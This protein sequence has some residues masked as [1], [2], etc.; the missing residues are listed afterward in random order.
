MK[1]LVLF[2]AAIALTIISFA[3][4]QSAEMDMIR[5]MF[6]KEWKGLTGEAL[7]LSTDEADKF[8]PIWDQYRED[9]KSISNERMRLI[10]DYGDNYSNITNDKAKELALGSLKNEASLNKLKSKYFKKMSKAVSPLR[11]AQFLQLENYIDS[12]IKAALTDALPFIPDPV[13]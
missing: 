10:K 9:R 8:W 1:R 4:D 5:Q 13:K 11:A 12:Q 6:G 3:Q 2:V 7:S